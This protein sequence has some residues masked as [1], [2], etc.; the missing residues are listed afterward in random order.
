[1]STVGI[2]CIR[3]EGP[4]LLDWIAHHQAVGFDHF[5]IASHDCTDG[6][7]ALLNALQATGLVTHVPFDP[8]GDA[9]IQ[10]QAVKLLTRH[11]R[12]K[13]ADIA[14]FFDVDE[15]LVLDGLQIDQLIGTA[16]AVPLRWHL[17]GHS[18]QSTYIDQPVTTRF[19]RAAPDGINL[20]LA[21]F[22]KTLHRPQAFRELG[23]HRPKGKDAQWSTASGKRLP[24]E[25]AAQQSRINLYGVPHQGERAWLNHYSIR[26]VEE[27]V[28]KSAR[29]LPNHMDKPIAAGYWAE[30]NFNTVEDLRIAPMQ[31]AAQ[32]ARDAL[33]Q[34][35]PLHAASVAHHRAALAS[36]V[37]KRPVIEFMWQL[38]LLAG[39]TPPT[40]MQLS[41]HI[42]RLKSLVSE[43]QN[44]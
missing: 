17:F 20:P 22:F 21:H 14:L 44:G 12:Y 10:W 41:A 7:D 28:L 5:L 40:Q 8:E 4:W 37:S 19:T 36:L 2:T 13:S 34:F 15:Y 24:P 16:D 11:D 38:E 30:R 27:F 26:S 1:M 39:S 6:T 29:G 33:A 9:S 42:S 35:D 31:A 43:D 18:G 25:F 32:A 23:I 3:N